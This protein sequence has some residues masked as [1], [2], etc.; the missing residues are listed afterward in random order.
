MLLLS[1]MCPGMCISASLLAQCLLCVPC[2]PEHW[3]ASMTILI[4]KRKLGPGE[5]TTFWLVTGVRTQ[6]LFDFKLGDSQ[7]L[8][9][10]VLS[11]VCTGKFCTPTRWAALLGVSLS[12]KPS[13]VS[14]ILS[15]ET[16]GHWEL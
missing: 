11:H 1:R 4:Y 9:R 2:S 12:L 16:E 5:V 14:I 6:N 7:A 3:D 10:L 15:I 8:L 13:L